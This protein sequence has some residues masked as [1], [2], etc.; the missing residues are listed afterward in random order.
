MYWYFDS[1][2]GNPPTPLGSTG[3]WDVCYLTFP[4][5]YPPRGGCRNRCFEPPPSDFLHSCPLKKH[6]FSFRLL[7]HQK[8]HPALKKSTH[9][10]T[11]LKKWYEIGYQNWL[12]QLFS[13]LR[14]CASLSSRLLFFYVLGH[15]ICEENV[16]KNSSLEKAM[17]SNCF[18]A[19]RLIHD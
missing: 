2:S 14:N 18:F 3:V 10:A 17:S 4:S 5:F 6:C 15:A 16:C 7:L 8:A 13:D 12:F 11:W 1:R 19:L 9:R